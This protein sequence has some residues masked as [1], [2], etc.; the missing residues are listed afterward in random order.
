MSLMNL[1]N[2]GT[3][4]VNVGTE[5]IPTINE[6]A[7]LVKTVGYTGDYDASQKPDGTPT[8]KLMDVGFLRGLG[9]EA[10]HRTKMMELKMV[11]GDG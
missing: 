10:R 1:H 11:Y 8:R 9:C 2:R 7:L 6:L 5:P 4:H 3:K